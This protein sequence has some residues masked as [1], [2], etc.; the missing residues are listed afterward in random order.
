[1]KNAIIP[2]ILFIL[3]TISVFS[4]ELAVEGH[5]VIHHSINLSPSTLDEKNE[6]SNTGD[7]LSDIDNIEQELVAKQLVWVNKLNTIK[8]I[9]RPV[10]GKSR[11]VMAKQAH[12]CI[13]QN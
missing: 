2:S 3:G 12:F 1:M 11:V 10:N 4:A 7:I 13:G 5:S 8:E 6:T 9:T